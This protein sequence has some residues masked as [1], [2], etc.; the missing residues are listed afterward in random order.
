MSAYVSVL[1]E[2]EDEHTTLQAEESLRCPCSK[3]YR[4]PIPLSHIESS[5]V[6]LQQQQEQQQQQQPQQPQQ[7][8]QKKKRG[9][10][11][12]EATASLTQILPTVQIAPSPQLI[13]LQQQQQ[14][15]YNTNLMQLLPPQNMYYNLL[16]P[17][18]AVATT[19]PV[20]YTNGY[21]CAKYA[22]HRRL[23]KEG[24]PPHSKDCQR[25]R[26]TI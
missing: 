5:S 21:C 16:P 6:S 13:Y 17:L 9:K 10:R 23:Q 3:C 14:M 12:K 1:K 20:Q 22:E 19:P 15:Y 18:L 11:R 2:I 4:H 8:Q 26:I 7:Q 24:R 25:R